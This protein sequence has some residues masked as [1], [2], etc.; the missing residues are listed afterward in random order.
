M[1]G[2]RVENQLRSVWTQLQNSRL[3]KCV[4]DGNV[5]SEDLIREFDRIL[6]RASPIGYQ[7]IAV[8][9]GW[10]MLYGQDR[11]QF[12]QYLKNT[13]QEYLL[14]V[15]D[16]GL[17][18]T[19][20]G[21]PHE[22]HLTWDLNRREFR[23]NYNA[24]QE[25][26][27]SS[28]NQSRGKGFK[29]GPRDQKASESPV[30]QEKQAEAPFEN[31]RPRRNKNNKQQNVQK[32][33]VL[34]GDPKYMELINDLKAKKTEALNGSNTPKAEEQSGEASTKLTYAQ[35]VASTPAV[36]AESAPANKNRE[37]LTTSA[38][39]V[40]STESSARPIT[41]SWADDGDEIGNNDFMKNSIIRG[42][43]AN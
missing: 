24:H 10:R 22:V 43:E 8:G 40:V 17:V 38:V 12:T 28:S 35:A 26:G 36:A 5:P 7:D 14:L 25:N 27:A 39:S 9:D 6:N 31:A 23:V 32:T 18:R 1:S 11:E 4:A 15:I 41:K 37:E 30:A 2:K 19:L 3:S 33:T 42:L 21:L 16:I 34:N 13:S 20:L 29:K